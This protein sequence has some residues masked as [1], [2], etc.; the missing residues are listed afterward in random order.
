M[1]SLG[2]IRLLLGAALLSLA[3]TTKVSEW[4]L[5]NSSAD[6]Y[7]LVYFH[8]NEL[9]EAE[10]LQHKELEARFVSANILLKSQQKEELDFS[11]YVLYY[12][13]RLL[14]EYK[15]YK[16]LEEIEHSV[17]RQKVVSE[18]MAGKL[19][20]MFYLRCGNQE[21][22]DIGFNSVNQ[23]INESPFK[24]VISVV[25]LDRNNREEK[26]F[27]SM[28]LNV[29]DDLKEINE[30]ML[31]GVFGRFRVLEPLLAKGISKDNINLMID[32]LSADCSCLIKDNLPGMSMLFKG[33]WEN[34]KPALVNK[35][36]D[37]NPQLE[38]R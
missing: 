23:A 22:D 2:Y 1:K 33:N 24:N 27:V 8:K 35:I 16:D 15:N 38:R 31:F 4:M 36:I 14:S 25:E 20:V 30:P 17:L 32:F 19:C 5:L 12:K 3:C 28:L 37:E 18:L 26:H 10:K 6:K 21:K 34:P 29:E 13:N 9:T 11:K 7:I